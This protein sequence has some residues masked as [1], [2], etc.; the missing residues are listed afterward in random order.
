[1]K[2]LILAFTI[3]AVVY[4]APTNEQREAVKKAHE[5]CQSQEATRI[6]SDVF[7]KLRRGEK[8]HNTQLSKHTLCMNV[9]AGLQTESGDINV[10]KLRKAITEATSDPN[11]VN[12][13]VE[14]CGKRVAGETAEETAVALFKCLHSQGP[15]HGHGH[16]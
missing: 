9:Q 5:H 15:P 12:T 11:L 2:C 4:A 1:M 3:L 14:K 6:D 16:H 7:D 13:I 10:D 8:V